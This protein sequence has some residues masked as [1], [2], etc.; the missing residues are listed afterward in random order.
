[1]EAIL[2]LW[3]RPRLPAEIRKQH[4]RRKEARTTAWL[5]A[6]LSFFDGFSLYSPKSDGEYREK[7][8]N[9][10]HYFSLFRLFW[11]QNPKFHKGFTIF[12]RCRGPPPEGLKIPAF[13]I[14]GGAA[15]EHVIFSEN[16]FNVARALPRYHVLLP[17][18]SNC[19]LPEKTDRKSREKA[20]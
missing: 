2:F 12:S 16:F 11:P 19:A 17:S 15:L 18:E 9:K 3:G 14:F 4:R 7:L 13:Q 20:E 5:S 1:M 8:S 10:I 6:P